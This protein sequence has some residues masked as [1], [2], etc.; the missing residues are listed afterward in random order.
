MIPEIVSNKIYWYLWRLKQRDLCVE[1]RKRVVFYNWLQLDGFSYN[2]RLLSYDKDSYTESHIHT[3]K[4]SDNN[5][6]HYWLRRIVSS[7]P[8]NYYRVPIIFD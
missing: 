7:L 8:K 6:M 2:Y 3:F 4:Y 5:F 1:Y